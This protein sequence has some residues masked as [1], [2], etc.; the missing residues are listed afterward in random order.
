VVHHQIEPF[1]DTH[2]ETLRVQLW[3]QAA[4][5]PVAV[6]LRIEPDNEERL[7]PMARSADQPPWQVY[8]A[9]WVPDRSQGIGVY[10]MAR[11]GAG[12][13]RCGGDRMGVDGYPCSPG[14]RAA[15]RAVAGLGVSYK[16]RPPATLVP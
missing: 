13:R 15:G 5:P 12:A 3:G 14:S 2:G 7:L 9:A 8:E 11:P 4:Q 10:W 1:L 6:F 16:P